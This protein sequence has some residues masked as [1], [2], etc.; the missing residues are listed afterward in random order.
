MKNTQK[1]TVILLLGALSI[2]STF[3]ADWNIF[4]SEAA[5]SALQGLCPIL[6]R[7]AES[8]WHEYE[9]SKELMKDNP[10]KTA[11]AFGILSYW[12]ATKATRWYHTKY[13]LSTILEDPVVTL[14]RMLEVNDQFESC[15]KKEKLDDFKHPDDK[16]LEK[17]RSL[18]QFYE[19]KSP[20][21]LLGECTEGGFMPCP[22]VR[23][24]QPQYREQFEARVVNQLLAKL[25]TNGDKTVRYVGFGSGGMYPDLRILLETLIKAP[26]DASI[27][28]DLIDRQY[29]CFTDVRDAMLRNHEV[30]PNTYTTFGGWIINFLDQQKLTNA[31]FCS[32]LENDYEKAELWAKSHNIDFKSNVDLTN[33]DDNIINANNKFKAM[34]TPYTRLESRARQFITFLKQSFPK[35][36]LTLRLHSRGKSYLE[37]ID[38]R[39]LPY[40]DVICAADITTD[41]FAEIALKDYISLCKTVLEKNMNTS[42]TLLSVKTTTDEGQLITILPFEA[43][44]IPREQFNLFYDFQSGE[45]QE[46]IEAVLEVEDI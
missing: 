36:K 21:F 2:S 46:T 20:I 41:D 42:N 12:G 19:N 3:P 13:P 26:D 16:A 45:Y 27:T 24:Q 23:A 33:I 32:F 38:K 30:T 4:L 10:I 28:I 43:E 22:L 37:Y 14:N 29:V 35:A 39:Q 7:A 6:N 5:Q 15:M 34:Q 40:P 17:L 25:K 9:K 31:I 1:L 18:I 44:N 11:V 8:S